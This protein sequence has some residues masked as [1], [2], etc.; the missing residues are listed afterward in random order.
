MPRSRINSVRPI[1]NQTKWFLWCA[2]PI[3]S[4]SGY[5][6]RNVTIPSRG[7]EGSGACPSGADAR[8][9]RGGVAARIPSVEDGGPRHEQFRAR[10]EQGH[11]VVRADAAVDLD[12]RRGVA[13]LD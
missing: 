6:T 4:T 10:L 2:I 1:S 9:E 11:D 7:M 5:R 3:G 12:A 13:S 8:R